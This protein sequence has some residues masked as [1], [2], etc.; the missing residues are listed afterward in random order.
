MAFRREFM[1][2]F[3]QDVDTF[4]STMLLNVDQLQKQLDKDEFQ[5]DGSMA[6]FWVVNNQFQKFIIQT[7]TLDYDSQCQTNSHKDS[8]K[9]G[10]NKENADAKRVRVYSDPFMTKT[11]AEVQLMMNTMI[12]AYRATATEQPESLLK[13]KVFANV[14]LKNELRKLKGNSVDTKFAK[15]SILGKPVLQPPRNQ[16]VVRQPNA[17][18]SE[19]PNFSKPRFASQVDVNNVLSKPVTQ[20]YLPKGRESAFAKP[21]HM[22]ASSSSRNSSKN[23][24]RFSSNDMVHNYYL[25]EAKKKTQERDRKSTTSVMPSAKSQNTTKSCKSKPRS[26]NQTSRVLP[27]SKSSC[28]TTTVMPKADHSRNSSP[29]SDFKHFVCS[30]CQKCVFNAN[31]DA[32]ITKFLKEVNSRAKIQPNKTRN[33]NKP[34]DPTS[35]TQKPGRKIVTGHSFSPNKSSAVHEKTNTP[36]SYL[37]WIPTGRIFNTAGLKWVPTGKTFTSSTTKV[38]CELPNGSNDYITNPYKCDQTLNVSAGTLNLSAVKATLKSAWTEKD[39]I[40]NLLKESRLMRSLEKFVGGK[41]FEGDLRLRQ[42]NHMI[43]SYDVLII[44]VFTMKMEILLE[45]TSNKLMVE[46]AEYDESNT[47]VLERFNTTAG[48]PVK[49]ILLKLNLSDHRLFKDGGGV[50][51]FQRSFRHSDTERL[52]RSDEVLKLKNFKKDA[53][54]KLFKSTNQVRYEHVGPTITSSQDG[55]VNKMAKRDYAWLMISRKPFTR[56]SD[57]YKE[58][59]DEFWYSATALENSKV[60]FSIPTGGIF[61]EVGVNTFRNAIGSHYLAYYSEYVAPPS[62]DVEDIIL[63]MKKKQREK[64]VP[65]TRFISLLIMHKIKE[66]YGDDELPNPLPLLR[67]F[68][69]AQSLELNLDTRSNLLQNKPLCPAKR[70]QKVGPLRH[71]LVPKLAILRKKESN[72]AMDS[73]L[74]QPLVSTYVDPGMH[75]EDQQAT[76]GPTSLWVTSEARAN[77]ELSSGMLAFNLTEPIYTATFIIHSKSASGNDASAVSIAEAD[78]GNSAPSTDLHV[79]V[80]QTKS[81]SDGLDTVLTQPLTG[82]G[83]SSFAKQ[84]EEEESFSTIKLE[85]LEKLVSN[86]QPSFKDLDSPE[87]D[88]VIIIEE[89]DEE[90]NDEIHATKNVETKDTLV[91]KSSSPKSSLIQ[92]LT[93]QVA[94]VQAKLKTLDALPGIL[95]HFTKA[96]NKF[97]QVLVS[98]LSKAGDKSV[99]LVGQANTMPAE[100][101]KNTN[102]AIIS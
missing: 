60:S 55:K 21:N 5:E 53:T 40:N 1:S 13:E 56:S 68:P 7:F 20:H 52:S 24:P 23:M 67:G 58:Y 86:V 49:K 19:R 15:P 59:L 41:L 16:S 66:G 84:V 42:K 39:Q 46:H 32:C 34:V 4:T 10:M 29:F 74:S 17:F 76:V 14:A 45:P 47:Y 89:S 61:G 37:R 72:S 31:H 64:V 101:E 71:P 18:K 75:K 87:D 12:F 78:L 73:N 88:P 57:M 82:K 95:S 8:M 25:E 27:T 38:D 44:Q 26:N 80:D 36:R 62:I 65:Y 85:D 83:A 9:E 43:L 22:I 54:L 102:Q 77:P 97:A 93:N 3:G 2:L 81:V 92:E 91:P 99:P 48:N 28:P 50:K 100:G 90:G 96:L 70:Q 11:M 94:T 98:A 30:T 33:S 69:K 51:E 79:L 6:A 35:H 63:K